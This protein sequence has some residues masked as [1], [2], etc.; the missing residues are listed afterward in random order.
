MSACILGLTREV[1][2]CHGVF[3]TE[4]PDTHKQ[5]QGIS[6]EFFLSFWHTEP[7][8]MIK[9]LL[10]YVTKSGDNLLSRNNNWDTIFSI[11]LPDLTP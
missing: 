4:T 8:K 6:T 10:F 2:S 9:Y 1:S 3:L 7:M 11:F 5:R